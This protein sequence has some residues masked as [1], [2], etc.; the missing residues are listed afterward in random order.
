MKIQCTPTRKSLNF[1][2]TE[3][4]E[5]NNENQDNVLSALSIEDLLEKK[6]SQV[7][8]V[9]VNPNGKVEMWHNFDEDRK[10]LL[11]NIARNKWRTVANLM[12]KNPSSRRN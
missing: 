2:N 12:F 3:Q 5:Q 6:T 10:S 9:I 7:K 1:K 4:P 8:V 11:L